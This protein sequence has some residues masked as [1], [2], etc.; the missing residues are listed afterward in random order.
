MEQF[1]YDKDNI[2]YP[3]RDLPYS[4]TPQ[5]RLDGSADPDSKQVRFASVGVIEDMNGNVLITRRNK[6]LKSFPLGWVFPGGKLDLKEDFISAMLR[7]V[8]EETGILITSKNSIN[9]YYKD[10]ECSIEKVLLYESLFPQDALAPNYQTLVIYYK[11]KIPVSYKEIKLNLQIGEVDAYVWIHIDDIYNI[12]KN[13]YKIEVKGKMYNTQ[14][15]RFEVYTFT[16]D[17]FKQRFI[18]REKYIIDRTKK[19]Y[20]PHGHRTAVK[21]IYESSHSK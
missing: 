20:M 1:K 15:K 6:N 2:L 4:H 10:K 8:Y 3:Y 12:L 17:N 21:I 19:E 11:V 16:H 7:E 18:N 5:C 13:E 14:T 9:Y